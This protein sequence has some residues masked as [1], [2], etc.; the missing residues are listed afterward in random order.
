MVKD[1]NPGPGSGFSLSGAYVYT[2]TNLFFT[3]DDG[4]FGVEL[5]KSDGTTSPAGTSMVADI[6]LDDEDSDPM[7]PIYLCN[8]KVMF[9]ATN[10][11]DIINTDLYVVNGTFTALPV[12]LVDFMVTAV[13]NDAMLHWT[14][15]QEINTKKFII[16]RSLDALHFQ[17]IGTVAAAGTSSGKHDYSF[18]DPGIINSGKAEVYY[19]IITSDLDAKEE[20][21]KVILLKLK[22]NN[23]WAVRMLSNPVRGN[24]NVILQGITGN[25]RLSIKEVTG[26]TIFTNT[27]QNTNGQLSLDANLHH[28]TYLLIAENNNERK[29]IKFIK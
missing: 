8:G 16:Q 2:T 27:Y 10:G 20:S 11:D 5:W 26:K 17:D 3:A 6:N 12:Q 22:I 23:S 28:G 29:I 21:S 24:V 7:L 1:I 15:S 9:G 19:R 25:V 14:T 13:G 18:T 4:N